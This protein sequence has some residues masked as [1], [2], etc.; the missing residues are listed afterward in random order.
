MNGV[1]TI[2]VKDKKIIVI[3][4]S[5]M[6]LRELVAVVTEAKDLIRSQ[7]PGS[8]LTLTDFTDAQATPAVTRVLKEF[9]YGNR[10]FVK[11]AA[12]VGVTGVMKSIYVAVMI[13]S[14]RK[15]PVFSDREKA[16][17]WL[18]EQ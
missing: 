11:A 17:K 15:I 1:K 6:E 8:V 5:G 2:E 7:P 10:P 12:L 16:V 4:L 18:L 3:D 14:S 13:F 9:A